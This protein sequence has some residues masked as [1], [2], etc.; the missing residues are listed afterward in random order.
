M[1]RTVI[2]HIYEVENWPG[3]PNK[4]IVVRREGE[5]RGRNWEIEREREREELCSKL[6]NLKKE[7]KRQYNPIVCVNLL[8]K[9][10]F[11]P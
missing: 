2:S 8:C 4:E 9:L 3:F 1:Q 11:C 5:E 6:R 7:L 10:M